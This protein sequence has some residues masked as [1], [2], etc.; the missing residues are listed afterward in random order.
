MSNLG[1]AGGTRTHD[2]R[3]FYQLSDGRVQE[4]VSAGPVNYRD[5]HGVWQPIS[6]SVAAVPAHGGFTLGATSNQFQAYFSGNAS[7]MVRL[8]QGSAFVQMGANGAHAAAAKVS[9]S[10]VTYPGV[11]PGVD[12]RYTVTPQGV[13]EQIVLASAQAASAAEKSGFSFTLKVG[14]FVPRQLPGG[15]VGFYG[16]E[17]ANPVFV[18]PAPYMADAHLDANSPYGVSYSA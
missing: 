7:S 10:S 15:A 2:P 14:G 8:E 12:L 5:A 9:A 4:R 13:K 18:I 6:T 1:R 11:Y 17:S 16:A 3:I